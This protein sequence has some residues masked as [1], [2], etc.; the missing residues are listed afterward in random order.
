MDFGD[1]EGETYQEIAVADPQGSARMMGLDPEFA[2]PSGELIESFITRING[3]ARRIAD[4][5]SNRLLVVTHGGVV[6]TLLSIC[7]GMDLQRGFHAFQFGPGTIAEI[8]L[9]PEG[10]VLRHLQQGQEA[11]S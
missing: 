10:A 1:W 6:R 11:T 4:C 8:M 9:F 3:A 7:L 2:P 5:P